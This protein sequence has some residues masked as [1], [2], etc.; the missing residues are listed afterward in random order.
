MNIAELLATSGLPTRR[1]DRAE[2]LSDG[3]CAVYLHAGHLHV[4]RD[5]TQ[6]TT[7]LGSCVS[8]CVWDPVAAIGGMNHYMLPDDFGSNSD[9][10]RHANFAMRALLQQLLDLG[11]QRAR[12]QAKLYGGA[13]VIV[14][15]RA[16]GRHLG[17]KNVEVGRA[18]LA[19]AQIPIVE[20]DTGEN[21]GRKVIF[22]TSTGLAIVKRV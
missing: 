8:V 17:Q 16:N 1:D 21:H 10:P 4:S 3:S 14:A 7:I 18:R 20:E 11:A 12:M 2:R 22:S 6:I 19:E 5:P 9:T 13:S 15:L